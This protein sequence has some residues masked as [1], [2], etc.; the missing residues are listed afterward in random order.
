MVIVYRD[1]LEHGFHL[2]KPTVKLNV[3]WKKTNGLFMVK[4]CHLNDISLYIVLAAL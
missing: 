2:A 4:Y 3:A 1:I